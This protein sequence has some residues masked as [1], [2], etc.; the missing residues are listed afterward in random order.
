M[1]WSSKRSTLVTVSWRGNG[2]GRVTA[3]RARWWCGD[4]DDSHELTAVVE[5]LITVADHAK[6]MSVPACLPMP[7]WRLLVALPLLEVSPSPNFVPSAHRSGRGSSPGTA[8]VEE[9]ASE[10][11]G[12]DQGGSGKRYDRAACRVGPDYRGAGENRAVGQDQPVVAGRGSQAPAIDRTA[13]GRRPGRPD[14]PTGRP[15]EKTI[16]HHPF[17]SRRLRHRVATD[18]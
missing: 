9:A 13:H 1:G 11:Q 4:S 16:E 12:L 8:N 15:E 7:S 10:P 6:S 14:L 2:G 18:P 17:V 3:Q 5:G